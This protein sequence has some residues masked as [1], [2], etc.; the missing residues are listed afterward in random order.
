MHADLDLLK[1]EL[2]AEHEEELVGLDSVAH[3]TDP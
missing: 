3:E 1:L 2:A